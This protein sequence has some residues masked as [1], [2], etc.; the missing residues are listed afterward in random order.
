MTRKFPSLKSDLQ[1]KQ[2]R[3]FKHFDADL[4]T[5]EL[6]YTHWDSYLQDSNDPN[7]LWAIWKTK[8][9]E[10]IDRNA[11]LRRQKIKSKPVPWLNRDYLKRKV[12]RTGSSAYWENLKIARN[13]VNKEIRNAKREYFKSSL[14]DS[15]GNTKNA[16]R[17]INRFLSCK[18]KS[19]H[20]SNIKLPDGS[21]LT[22]PSDIAN[23]LNSHFA[24]VGQKMAACV[25]DNGVP[26]EYYMTPTNS[27]F[28]LKPTT[29][30]IV[31]EI[32]N[33]MSTNKATGLDGISSKILKVSSPVVAPA[34]T[35]IFNKAIM[36]A[37]FR[38]NGK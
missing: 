14:S 3:S 29:T 33:K 38:M 24:G 16:W 13:N 9:M 37:F 30:D 20:I 35:Y 11:P 31:A 23:H 10:I 22:D 34:L 1:S 17:V 4:F 36:R 25:N 6:S 8:F 5:E 15:N 18:E 26:P 28:S 7:E 2:F 12:V 32:M 21:S 19:E 27:T